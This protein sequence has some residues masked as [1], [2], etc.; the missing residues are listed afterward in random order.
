MTA[1]LPNLNAL[2]PAAPV[3]PSLADRKVRQTLRDELRAEE[4]AL[5]LELM[6][7]ARVVLKNF[8]AN[9]HKTSAADLARLVELA[10]KLGRLATDPGCDL[11]VTDNGAA[12]MIEFHAALRKVYARRESEGRPLPAGVVIDAETVATPSAPADQP[13][14][15]PA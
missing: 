9:P 10:S 2:A 6:A 13:E 1:P 4:W 5:H 3:P 14:A 11:E 15:P 12:V 8:F 7:A